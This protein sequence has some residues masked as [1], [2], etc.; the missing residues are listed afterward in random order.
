MTTSDGRIEVIAGSAMVLAGDDIDTD[1]IIPA[2]YLK[3]VTFDGLG[4]HVFA[5]DRREAEA[6]G[7]VHP[8][9]DP[10]TAKAAILVVGANFGCGSSREHA[11][12]AIAQTGVRAIVG[13]SFAEIFVNNAV[14]IGLPCVVADHDALQQIRNAA[15]SGASLT[16]DLRDRSVVWG[17][18]RM[19]IDIADPARDAFLSGGWDGTAQLL[20]RYEEVD[21][22]R[23]RL[24]YPDAF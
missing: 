2:R 10:A 22:V 18:A 11:P 17:S 21:A 20:E 5:D 9:D 8:F 14:Q 23:L 3:A 4:R 16:L 1:R 24:P 6:A 19:A 12:R 7:R 15:A 13:Q